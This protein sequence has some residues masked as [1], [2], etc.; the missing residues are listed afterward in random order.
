[1]NAFV[2]RR[3]QPGGLTLGPRERVL[4]TAAGTTGT[5]VAT[6]RRLLVPEPGGYYAVGWDRVDRAAWDGDGEILTVTETA[7]PGTRARE[8]RLRVEEAARLLDVVREQVKAS[9]II[10]RYLLIEGDRGVRV[11][12]R[13]RPGHGGLS[14]V[15]AVDNGLDL[16]VPDVRARVAAAV[17]EVRAEVE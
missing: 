4:A 10:S 1:M 7:P 13:R 5:V 2:R 11:T 14:W 3:I 17:A 8:H 9:L 12:G 16:D 6:D 15:V